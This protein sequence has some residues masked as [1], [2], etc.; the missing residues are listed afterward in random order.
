MPEFAGN[1]QRNPVPVPAVG[2]LD[3]GYFEKESSI[4]GLEKVDYKPAGLKQL[5]FNSKNIIS[6][7]YRLFIFI[8][9]LFKN[10][11][12]LFYNSN[13]FL[14]LLFKNRLLLLVF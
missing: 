12:L 7:F 14:F 6:Y 8:F 4:F 5:V 10:P 2:M 3:L 1:F 13:F 11:F 9:F